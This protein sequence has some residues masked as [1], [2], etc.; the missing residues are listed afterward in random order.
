MRKFLLSL[1]VLAMTMPMSGQ[2]KLDIGSRGRLRLAQS[3]LIPATTPQGTTTIVR[4]APAAARQETLL[5]GFITLRPGFE[6][7]LLTDNGID[8]HRVLGTLI[9]ASFTPS[10]LEMLQSLDGVESVTLSRPVETKMNI[11]RNLTGVDLI[12]AGTDLPRAY[13]GKGVITGIIDGGFQFAHVNFLDSEGQPRIKKLTAL[14]QGTS[15]ETSS[16]DVATDIATLRELASD[17]PANY[18]GTHTLG[19][20]AGGYRGKVSAAQPTAENP[21]LTEN[22]EIDNPYYGI[23]TGSDIAIG[24]GVL[25]DARI[26][27]GIQSIIDYAY[28]HNQP[29]VINL[30]LGSN[31][32]PHD[33]TSPLCQ[34][35]DYVSV[36]QAQPVIFVMSAGNEGYLPI[37]LHKTLSGDDLTLKSCFYP[38]VE[39][40][41]Y[42]NLRYGQTYFY[43]ND[44]TPFDIQAF[45][46]NKKRPGSNPI[47]RMPLGGTAEGGYK[48]WVTDAY[49]AQDGDIVATQM[50][51]Y[52]TGF[53][54]IGSQLD[55]TSGRY[56]AMINLSLYDNEDGNPDGDYVLGFQVTGKDGQRIDVY[57][58]SQFMYFDSYG[59]GS[60]Y[61]NGSCDG[62]I[63]DMACG[64]TPVIVGS[65]NIRDEYPA[66]DGYVYSYNGRFADAGKVSD[67]TSYGTLIDGRTLPTVCAP[68]ATV[69]S[70]S[71]Y[72]YHVNNSLG[73]ESYSAAVTED[74]QAYYW[75]QMPGTSMSSPVVA[76]SIALWLEA[77]PTLRWDDVQEIIAKTSKVDADVE[78]GNPVQWGA[79]KFD[80]YA[81]LKEVLAGAGITNAA[82]DGADSRL[83]VRNLG[84]ELEIFLAG[85]ETIDA[86]LYTAT[87]ALAASRRANGGET[88]LDTS[89]LAPGVYILNVNSS[90]SQRII[91]K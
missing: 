45:I 26:A 88:R 36:N 72:Y 79:G 15:L 56:Y 11:A 46:I 81:G 58:D 27:V 59:H 18:H 42:K 76:G 6:I 71:N 32:G 35:M 77:D 9:A 83:M 19:I 86:K 3:E 69:I 37:A 2:N 25:D 40:P 4:R 20:M 7:A 90:H 43:S 17:D 91:I 61:V 87:G 62:S 44:A 14:I 50:A 29:T 23:A 51:K 38:Y 73:A 13:T 85:A 57:G 89:R 12:H 24:C 5:T 55:T 48:A 64:H 78:A 16:A 68:G 34:A 10:Q 28:D 49:N 75:Q 82:A 8:A 47:F 33:G 63:S 53:V 39:T 41:G 22:K 66:N 84:G 65:Y 52:F 31:L 30:S 70:S 1:A 67:F 80:A 21:A 74:G 60:D 54:E